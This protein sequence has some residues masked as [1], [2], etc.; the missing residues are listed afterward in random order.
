M[1]EGPPSGPAPRSVDLDG[2]CRC[3]TDRALTWEGDVAVRPR[4][5]RVTLV[6]LAKSSRVTLRVTLLGDNWKCWVA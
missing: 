4:N 1:P 2:R 3:D 6:Q 5:P